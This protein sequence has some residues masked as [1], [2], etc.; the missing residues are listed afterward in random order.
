MA[1]GTEYSL[2]KDVARGTNVSLHT[3]G[4]V[5]HSLGRISGSITYKLG[6]HEDELK[7]S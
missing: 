4:A 7:S 6:G 2:F 1:H 5:H 3:I